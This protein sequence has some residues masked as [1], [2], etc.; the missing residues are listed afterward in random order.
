M[1]ESRKNCFAYVSENDM[2]GC[3]AL[4]ELYCKK[5]ECKFYQERK[6]AKQKYLDTYNLQTAQTIGKSIDKY[7]R[8]L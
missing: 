2:R 7:F 3:F 6:L 1:S 5:E 8:E 4:N